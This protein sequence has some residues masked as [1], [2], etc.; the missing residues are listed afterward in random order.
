MKKT[1][2]IF[3]ALLTALL[4]A[5]PAAADA[6]ISPGRKPTAPRDDFF[7]EHAEE[8]WYT[9]SYYFDLNED[10]TLYK[11]PLD[12][13]PC[14]KAEKNPFAWDVFSVWLWSG[15][16]DSEG[17][18][19]REESWLYI[20]EGK[21]KGWARA[22]DF[23]ITESY[24]FCSNAFLT[25]HRT[26]CLD[27]Y[28]PSKSKVHRSTPIYESPQSD[29]PADI[30]PEGE[31][32][33]T[34]AVWRSTDWILV[35]RYISFDKET[36][37]KTQTGWVCADALTLEKGTIVSSRSEAPVWTAAAIPAAGII[38]VAVAAIVL[39]TRKKKTTASE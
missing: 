12:Q 28:E 14:G 23:E 7:R 31:M 5:A 10:T 13:A 24:Y 20:D 27:T 19:W 16:A 32:V 36:G 8:C 6:T 21:N 26:D 30:V 33:T 38:A 11:S 18:D 17:D 34:N 22:S 39:L 4:L 1:V 15:S 9:R 29:S 37:W 25:E 35:T 3:L 2:S